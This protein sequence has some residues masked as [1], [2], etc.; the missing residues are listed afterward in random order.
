MKTIKSICPTNLLKSPYSDLWSSG[1]H[2]VEADKVYHIA[3]VLQECNGLV[4]VQLGFGGGTWYLKECDWVTM[5]DGERFNSAKAKDWKPQSDVDQDWVPQRSV[6]TVS[7]TPLCPLDAA[8]RAEETAGES[9]PQDSNGSP[10]E[11][12]KPA[13]PVFYSQRDNYRDA[14]RSCFSS[15]AATLLKW[16]IPDSIQNDDEYLKKVFSIGD[17]VE[18]SVQLKALESYGLTPAFQT[19]WTMG[20]LKR[21][22]AGRTGQPVCLGVLHKGKLDKPEN[23]GGHWVFCF[24]YDFNTQEALIHDPNGIYD[25]QN[26]VHL[27]GSGANQRWPEDVLVKRW[28]V[29]AATGNYRSGWTLFNNNE[30][31]NWE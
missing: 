8:S 14:H 11:G 16:H 6:Q 30:Y 18:A 10:S 27:G 13:I 25:Y 21:Q 19:D 29:E 12:E 17:T 7:A 31:A 1:V 4:Q 15:A 5:P 20:R 26:G 2:T 24:G 28:T 23:S 9:R 22:V 3:K